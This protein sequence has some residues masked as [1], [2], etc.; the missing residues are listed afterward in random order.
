[1]ERVEATGSVQ[2]LIAQ[3]TLSRAGVDREA[4][5]PFQGLYGYIYDD[6]IGN[7]VMSTDT[8]ISFDCAPPVSNT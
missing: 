3:A 1:M 2:M 6:Y 4:I 8:S 5:T 7:S